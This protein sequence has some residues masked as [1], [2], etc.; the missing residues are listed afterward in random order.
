[1]SK[2]WDTI[3]TLRGFIVFTLFF[4]SAVAMILFILT[5]STGWKKKTMKVVG[6]FLELSLRGI[7]LLAV[8]WIQF[9][10]VTYMLVFGIKPDLLYLTAL[11]GLCLAA[12]ILTASIKEIVSHILNLFLLGA[13]LTTE[14]IVVG[15]MRDVHFEWPVVVMAACLGFFILACN[16][17]FLLKDVYYLSG[18]RWKTKYEF[19]KESSGCE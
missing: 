19:R 15:Y 11:V 12:C 4:T 18:E 8:N 1:M 6:V 3:Y 17:F 5:S 13:A 16:V 14:Y 9:C 2:V 7:S 10:M